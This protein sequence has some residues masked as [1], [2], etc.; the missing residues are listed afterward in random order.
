MANTLAY[1]DTATITAIKRFVVQAPGLR[2]NEISY[3]IKGF[4][5]RALVLL[6]KT[7]D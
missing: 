4:I 1:N 3:C 5:E 7:L 2:F 6:A